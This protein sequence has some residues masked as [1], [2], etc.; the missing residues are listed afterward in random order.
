M[1]K[2]MIASVALALL[3][4][5]PALAERSPKAPNPSAIEHAN[6]DKGKAFWKNSTPHGA[7]V[8]ALAASLPAA[9]AALG[10]LGLVLTTR[11]RKSKGSDAGS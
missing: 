2:V 1:K 6:L 8:P 11:R 5:A 7:P 9:A 4:A 3:Y 10:S